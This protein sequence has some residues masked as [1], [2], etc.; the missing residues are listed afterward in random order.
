MT[1]QE[2]A[3]R[4]ARP[5]DIVLWGATGFTGRLVAEHL[6]GKEGVRWAM[7]GRSRAK[8]EA[9][10]NDVAARFPSAA[11][12]PLLIGDAA[13]QAS[14][15]AIASQARVVASTVGPFAIHGEPLVAACVA[16]RTD[17]CDSTGEPNFIRR[18]IDAHH[19]AARAAGVRIVPTCGFDSIPSDLGTFLL[20]D[21]AR[22]QGRALAEV[23][24]YVTAA[25]GGMSGGTVASM[26]QILDAVAHDRDMRR[27]LADPYSLSPD[28]ANDLGVDGRDRIAPR[29]DAEAGGWAAP[30][31][32]AGINSRVVR[33][34]NALLG[35]R[36]GKRF[37][38]EEAMLM[39][40]RVA[41][42]AQAAAMTA[43]FAAAFTVLGTS[44]AARDLAAKKL[45]APGQGPPR[46]EREAGYFKLRLYGVLE[47][48]E[49]ASLLARVDGKGDPGYA[50][51]SRMVGESAL[52]LALD[53][54]APGFE[55]G[56]LTPATALGMHL[57]ERL[58]RADIQ[59]DVS[60][61]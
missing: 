57:V 3:D 20:A 50:A 52:C 24:A 33:R 19:E 35:H 10:R 13:D 7:A 46:A 28:R 18:I 9:T 40:G 43:A 55:G 47:G 12:V 6:A 31:V 16:S 27:L 22:S 59:L 11:S 17:Y 41:G 58:R 8:L 34:S 4:A 38:Y 39:R 44:K 29:W 2:Q 25:K 45:P 53:P 14:L 48:D 37:R 26:L 1:T 42:A 5:F 32:M 36:Y 49:R 15:A 54:A 56:V 21:H 23:R 60:S 51:T 30:W 61:L